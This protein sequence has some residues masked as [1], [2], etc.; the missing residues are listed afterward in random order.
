M[1]F[2]TILLIPLLVISPLAFAA[3]PFM[4]DDARITFDHSCQLESW[5]RIYSKSTEL[6]A[7]PACNFTGNLEIT[8]GGGHAS[9]DGAPSSNDYF[10]QG[11]SMIRDL[12][13]NDYGVA[14]AVGKIYHPASSAG[15]NSFGSNYVYMPVTFS[16]LDDRA[17]VHTNLGWA[18][19][20]LTQSDNLTWGIGGEYTIIKQV[21][22]MAETFGDN[23]NHPFWQTGVRIFIIPD[24]V[25]ID[26]TI[27]N[28]RYGDRDSRWISIG[29]RLTPERL[30]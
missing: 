15:P 28:Q 14:L 27:G 6:W 12:K 16:L 17:F 3:R 24:R 21:N 8:A 7:F 18:R 11:K 9:Y 5:T 25:Q 2:R 26:S 22:L 20:R 19:D 29:I 10:L 13:T 23:R 30:F 1:N 4:T